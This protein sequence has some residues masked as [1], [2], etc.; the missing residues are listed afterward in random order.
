MQELQTLQMFTFLEPLRARFGLI[1]EVGMCDIS[2]TKGF[3]MSWAKNTSHQMALTM[4]KA[5]PPMEQATCLLI[6]LDG[7]NCIGVNF[8]ESV[9]RLFDFNKQIVC[10]HAAGEDKGT[11]GRMVI[12]LQTFEKLN[13]YD[14]EPGIAGSGYQDI[15]LKDR[16]MRLGACHRL[17]WGGE[18]SE[19]CRKTIGCALRNTY[20][21]R[22]RW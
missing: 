19:D 18:T 15:D 13:G 3:H 12:L 14:Q 21:S 5:L 8:V 1:L 6:N 10:L 16:S 22:P 9:V 2:A 17:S 20:Q 7:D 4:G 11:T